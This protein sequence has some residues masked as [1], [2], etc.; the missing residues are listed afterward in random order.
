ML[1]KWRK[2]VEQVDPDLIIGYNIA[3]FDL[4]YLLDRAKAL[5]ANQFPYLG[6][7]KSAFLDDINSFFFNKK[8]RRP[9]ADEGYALLF[10][11]IWTT[12]LQRNQNGRS[13][14]ARRSSVHATGAE[15][16]ELHAQLGLRT[17][18][19]RAKGGR[20]PLCDHRVA[21]RNS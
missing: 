20:P 14:A 3:N 4:P 2:F 5:K 1:Q 19:G 16:A 17:V 12:R 21:E 10:K 13:A 9:H 15:I 7:L 8:S 11:S 6:R 18:S